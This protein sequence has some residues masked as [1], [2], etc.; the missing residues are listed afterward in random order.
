MKR[1]II[2][3][4]T[5]FIISVAVVPVGAVAPDELIGTLNEDKGLIDNSINTLVRDSSNDLLY[6]GTPSG[7]SVYDTNLEEFIFNQTY[8]TNLN[9]VVDIC[10][11]YNGDGAYILSANQS[12]PVREFWGTPES[13]GFLNIS[14]PSSVELSCIIH[15]NDNLLF[16]GSDDGL[17]EY[18]ISWPYTLTQ[19]DVTH[20][21]VS[22]DNQI[23]AMTLG[24]SE[25]W[26]F[27]GTSNGVWVF[28]I[29]TKMFL[30]FNT[31]ETLG[32]PVQSLCFDSPSN[33]LY[34]GTTEGLF[35]YALT[36]TEAT[37]VETVSE[38][39]QHGNL[40]NENILSVGMDSS[41]RQLYIGTEL[42]LVK[43]DLSEST[44][45]AM[46]A[47]GVF[48]A[49]LGFSQLTDSTVTTISIDQSDDL[50][51]VGTQ[52]GGVN[53]F[54]IAYHRGVIETGIIIIGAVIVILPLIVFIKTH[55]GST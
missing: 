8:S 11:S 12:Y 50:L 18:E 54:E 51:Y 7:M 23:A 46:S 2:V 3:I 32:F 26:L 40:A 10:N 20:D 1:G 28:D 48:G 38:S 27:I 21:N 31:L 37:F 41:N 52:N 35:I 19:H 29:D 6:I 4:F 47:V 17:F 36:E 30:D 34:V 44:G 45:V 49:E 22:L 24:K 14:L 55:G 39:V 33:E 16:L 15:T 42:E 53:I 43:Y 5:F 25:H 9:D 13:D